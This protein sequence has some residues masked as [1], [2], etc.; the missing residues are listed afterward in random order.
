MKRFLLPTLSVVLT[1]SIVSPGLAYFS[2]P[3]NT[4]GGRVAR[5]SKRRIIERAE[6]SH[7]LP[8]FIPHEDRSRSTVSDESSSGH[9]L[10]RRADGRRFRRLNRT[11]KPG[12]D[13]YRTLNLRTN[14]RSLRGMEYESHL[15]IPRTLVQTGGYDHPT[16]R[17]IRENSYF[18]QVNDRD[19]NILQEISDSN[20]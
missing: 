13:R 11:P 7:K 14:R 1:L 9:R 18:N 20:R 3:G 17:D 12:F 15:E 19:R 2:V 16:R 8:A 10:L 5:M 4:D 6:A